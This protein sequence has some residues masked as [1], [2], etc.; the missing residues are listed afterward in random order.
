METYTPDIHTNS[1]EA[2]AE[3]DSKVSEPSVNE[4]EPNPPI[5]AADWQVAEDAAREYG[6]MML[7]KVLKMTSGNHDLA[8]D[9]LQETYLRLARANSRGQFTPVSVSGWLYTAAQRIV[10]GIH[11][12]E[13]RARKELDLAARVDLTTLIEKKLA[14]PSHEDIKANDVTSCLAFTALQGTMDAFQL[15]AFMACDI[16]GA[17]P[18]KYAESIDTPRATINTRLY[19]ARKRIRELLLDPDMLELFGGAAAIEGRVKKS[20]K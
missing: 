2:A 13:E 5:T 19:R 9:V 20:V 12:K 7:T 6:D 18:T 4:E 10:I 11:R 3:E 14:E 8:H 17:S 16:G 1:D 15:S